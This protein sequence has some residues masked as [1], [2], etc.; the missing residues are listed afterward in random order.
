MDIM[1]TA[2]IA[3][4]DDLVESLR[5]WQQA[6]CPAQQAKDLADTVNNTAEILSP[7]H[8]TLRELAKSS[9]KRL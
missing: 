3:A 6:G 4:L 2:T 5:A 8:A 1:L 9:K 7:L